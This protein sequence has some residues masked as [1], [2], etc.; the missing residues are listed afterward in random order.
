VT[1]LQL[2]LFWL[3]ACNEKCL[4]LCKRQNPPISGLMHNMCIIMLG[5]RNQEF[6]DWR[7]RQCQ[8][9]SYVQAHFDNSGY[10][11]VLNVRM[12][13][14]SRAE[15]LILL[16]WLFLTHSYHSA[17]VSDFLANILFASRWLSWDYAYLRA[18]TDME[19]RVNL[20]HV[21]PCPADEHEA[22]T[23]IQP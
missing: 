12:L 5:S 22:E 9:R 13:L 6:G 10:G 2:K 14:I 18:D 19:L 3:S 7:L 23:N 21:E 16:R 17:Q 4:V 15:R 11:P 20:L 8:A 1:V